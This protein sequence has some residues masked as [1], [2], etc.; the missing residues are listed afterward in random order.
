MEKKQA[1]QYFAKV[2]QEE[3]DLLFRLAFCILHNETDAEDAV[4]DAILKAWEKRETLRDSEKLRSWL[5]RILL[6]QSKTMLAKRKREIPTEQV[7]F[8]AK[9]VEGKEEGGIWDDVMKLPE[10]YRIVIILYYYRELSIKE[11]SKA[12]HISVGTVK[13]QLSRA[14][15]KL[16]VMCASNRY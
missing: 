7:F 4:S 12:L 11:I 15:E 10:K 5:I 9:A 8:E 13:S 6:N 3:Q 16:R 1:K 2:I 14:K